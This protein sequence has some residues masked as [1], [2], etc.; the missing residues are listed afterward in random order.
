MNAGNT[1]ALLHEVEHRIPLVII[2]K[3]Q[4][5]SVVEQNGVVLR[6][7]LLI[8]NRVLICDVSRKRTGFFTEFLDGIITGGN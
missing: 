7:I 5:G 4:M 8:K 3:N 6:K 1:L 2:L